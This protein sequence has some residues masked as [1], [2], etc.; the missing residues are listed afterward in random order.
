MSSGNIRNTART[1]GVTL[2]AFA[3]TCAWP[4][5]AATKLAV[6]LDP[7]DGKVV[8]DI[9]VEFGNSLYQDV[10]DRYVRGEDVR[11]STLRQVW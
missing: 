4:Q 3:C 1:I 5:A 8:N 11:Y 7:I 6:P 2:V 9:V 10:M